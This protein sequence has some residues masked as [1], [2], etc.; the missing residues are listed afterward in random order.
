MRVGGKC[1]EN[2]FDSAL[3]VVTLGFFAQFAASGNPNKSR[4]FEGY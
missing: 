3:L 1:L 2:R 4:S